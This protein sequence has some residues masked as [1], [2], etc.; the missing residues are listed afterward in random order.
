MHSAAAGRPTFRALRLSTLVV[1]VAGFL[2]IPCKTALAQCTSLLRDG[3]FEAQRSGYVS[4]PWKPEGR[5]GIDVRRGFSYSGANNAWAR[6]IVGWNGIRQKV[7]L[8]AGNVYKLKAFVRTS[9]NV[10]AG[11]F[12]FRNASQRPLS[13][14]K[15]GKLVTY[16]ELRVSFRPTWTG[17]YYVF[18][19]FWAP[20]QDAW[21]Q[22][23]NVRVE[24]PCNDVVLN[25]APN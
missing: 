2:L 11:Y 24:A 1:V 3:D 15:F 20:G 13:E 7:R 19:G 12:G 6:N 17:T 10:R 8:V 25:P 16:R 22:I 5:A 14:I 9:G 21:I 18:T 4:T 23:D